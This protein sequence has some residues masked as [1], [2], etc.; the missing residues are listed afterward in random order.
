MKSKKSRLAQMGLLALALSLT[1]GLVSGSIA[2]A[3]KKKGKSGGSVTIAKTTPTALPPASPEQPTGCG[4]PP[5][6]TPCTVSPKTSLT[7]V[8]LTVGKK[9]KNQVVSLGSVSLSYT[10]TGSARTGAGTATD[11]P[12]A[13][14]NVGICLTAPNGRTACASQPG[15]FDENAT[16]IGPVTET[17]DSPIGVCPTTETGTD[18]TQTVCGGGAFFSQ[19]DPE[20]TVAPPTYAGTIG[21]NSLAFF[22]GVPAK[23][24][25]TFKLRNTSTQTPATVSSVSA[26]IGLTPATSS[27]G[28]GKKKK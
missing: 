9:A 15:S 4:L 5:T 21:N 19:Q 18:G 20:S 2:H 1:V 17:P 10:I 6:F 25:W 27:S 26:T 28:G 16:T 7:T 13:A 24:T 23:G 22:G 8:P 12:A 3:K 14:S 11:V